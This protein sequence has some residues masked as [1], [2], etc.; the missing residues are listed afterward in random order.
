MNTQTAITCWHITIRSLPKQRLQSHN[1]NPT[2]IVN[3]WNNCP[4]LIMKRCVFVCL[5]V[6]VGKES[7]SHSKT[8]QKDTAAGVLLFGCFC[9]G[10][11]M[12][13]ASPQSQR[14]PYWVLVL[15]TETSVTQ[16]LEKQCFVHML[17]VQWRAFFF[18]L[19]WSSLPWKN[20]NLKVI[21]QIKT[22]L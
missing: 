21:M 1:N 16:Q 9:G 3:I 7:K 2:V 12:R 22:Q 4:S 14:P 6:C 5:C 18:L 11:L 17:K 15:S 20:D 13:W 19:L 8:P 10:L